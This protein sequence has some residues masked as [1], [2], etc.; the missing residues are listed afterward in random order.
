MPRR[1]SSLH[2]LDEQVSRRSAQTQTDFAWWPCRS[3]CAGCCETLAEEPQVTRAEWTRLKRAVDALPESARGRIGRA[4]GRGGAGASSPGPLV[5]PLLESSSGRC[6][7]YAARPLTCRTYGFYAGRSGVRA[8]DLVIAGMSERGAE[9]SVC[10]GNEDA[11]QRDLSRECGP[12]RSLS[13]WWSHGD[14]QG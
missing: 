11:I 13:W 4:L 14:G 6:S 3:G 5:C 2:I 9:R 1:V 12:A 7:V 10:W 8:C